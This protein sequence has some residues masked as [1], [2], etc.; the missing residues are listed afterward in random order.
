MDLS[1]IIVGGLA[2]VLAISLIYYFFTEWNT[3]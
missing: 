2:G 1:F 3:D